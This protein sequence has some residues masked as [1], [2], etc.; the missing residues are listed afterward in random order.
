MS[1]TNINVNMSHIQIEIRICLEDITDPWV[2]EDHEEG[3]G[4]AST[5]STYGV[6]VVDEALSSPHHHVYHVWGMV[7]ESGTWDPVTV[8]LGILVCRKCST[9]WTYRR[10]RG[11]EPFGHSPSLIHI[12]TPGVRT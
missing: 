1:H 5:T 3:V 7:E 6:P 11:S 10:S 9:G 12:W 4:R 2:V 8:A